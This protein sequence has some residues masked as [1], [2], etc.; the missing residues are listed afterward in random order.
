MNKSKSVRGNF[1][2]KIDKTG[3]DL[4]NQE[5]PNKDMQAEKISSIIWNSRV[6]ASSE[7]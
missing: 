7:K 2:L 6:G 5:V 1:V 3:G 4:I